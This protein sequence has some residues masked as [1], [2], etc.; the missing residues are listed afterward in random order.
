MGFEMGP[1][2]LEYGDHMKICRSGT[3]IDSDVAISG[4]NADEARER[5]VGISGWRAK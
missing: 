4:W 5:K 2:T 1:Q 3:E